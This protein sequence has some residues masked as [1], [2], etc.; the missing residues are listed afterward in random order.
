MTVTMSGFATFVRQG[1]KIGPA[2]TLAMNAKMAIQS[3]A[4]TVQ[5]TAQNSSVSVDQDSNASSTVI[6]GKD[7]DVLSDDPD[8]LSS[9]LTALAGPAAGP[10]GGQVYVDGFTGGQ[11]PPKSSIREVRINQNPFSTQ[12]DRLGYGRV[13]VFTK[14]GT[15][16][17]HGSAQLNANNSSFNTGNPLL[18]TNLPT[19]LS[20]VVQPPYHT[21]FSFGNLTGPL[22]HSASFSLGG[23]YRSIQDN[24]IVNG[25]IIVP[26]S[27]STTICN[28]GDTGCILVPYQDAV[29]IPQTRSEFTPRLDLALGEKN[30]LTGRY[31]YEQNS[32]TNSGVGSFVT[33]TAGSNAD[34]SENKIQISDTQ[35]VNNHVI[36]ETRFEYQ[37]EQSSVTALSTD[38][39]VSVQGAFTAGGSGAGSSTDKQN[40]FEVQNY[41]SIQLK[42]HFMRLGGRLRLAMESDTLVANPHGVFTYSS[43]AAYLAN[44]PSQFTFTKVNSGASA[45]N[46]DVGIYAE[47][48]WKIRPNLTLSYG[49]RYEGQNFISERHDFA[50]RVAFSYGLGHNKQAPATVIRGGFGIFYNRFDLSN[51]IMTVQQNGINQVN[52]VAI[53][54]TI[55]ALTCSPNTLQN[56]L[57]LAN[58]GGN[59]TYVASPNLRSPYTLQYAIGVDQQLF[60]GASMSVNYLHAVGDHQFISLVTSTS[61]VQYQFTSN[62]AFRQ[63]QIVTNINL[64]SSKYYSLFGYYSLN[65]AKSNTAGA[66]SFPSQSNNLDAD[67]GRATFST[68]SRIFLGG[69]I[70]APFYISLS[71]FIVAA[72]GTP[73]NITTGSDVNGDS[74][75]TD[76]PMFA[77][78]VS[79]RCNVHDDFVDPS[80]DPLNPTGPRRVVTNYKQIPINYCTGPSLFS[81]NLRVSKTFGFGPL[82]ES[83]ARAAQRRG[84]GGGPRGGF[85]GGHG[86]HGGT[87]STGQ[88]Y[89][90]ALGAQVQNLFNYRALGVPVGTLSSRQFGSSTQL[91]GNPYTSNS[92]VE[93]LQVFLSFNF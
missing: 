19:G 87:V 31:Q 64:R 45:T 82:T 38:A 68:R 54:K 13:Q 81:M 71:P 34:S 55:P 63:N 46:A 93:R 18:N 20:P 9:E 85:G 11:L 35:I 28:P 48:D 69:S 43:P 44:Q 61:P 12:F 83:G 39:S 89:N 30:T 57:A 51:Q 17:F 70:Y 73:Y 92:A 27:G 62:G 15:D 2:Q 84:G 23:S 8:E 86:G 50:P 66:G 56:C 36:N 10:N 42:K 60:P 5:V 75:Y 7:L 59:Q 76:R 14:P 22:S 80:I 37:R 1:V 40:Y 72:S 79:G 24:A 21:I 32:R 16:N 26:S 65:F 47:D 91:A 29:T 53:I 78:G 6:N 74:K 77:N 90:V 41:T 25:S 3:Q 49:L 52:S 67:Y 33:A 88:R 58:S 4:Q